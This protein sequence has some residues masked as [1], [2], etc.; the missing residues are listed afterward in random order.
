[1]NVWNKFDIPS[2]FLLKSNSNIISLSN[3]KVSNWFLLTSKPREEQRAF[4]NLSN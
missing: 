3:V 1:M 4:Y 2:M